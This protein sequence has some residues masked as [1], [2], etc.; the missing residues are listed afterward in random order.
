MLKVRRM[1]VNQGDACGQRVIGELVRM[2]T[3]QGAY[4]WS[5]GVL[6]N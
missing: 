2:L 6:V 5:R 3:D 4:S 1:L